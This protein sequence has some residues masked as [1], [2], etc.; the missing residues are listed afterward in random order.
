MLIHLSIKIIASKILAGDARKKKKNMFWGKYPYTSL[1]IFFNELAVAS[2]FGMQ[3]IGMKIL[4]FFFLLTCFWFIIVVF[5][6]S[7]YSNKKEN[8]AQYK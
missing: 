5:K 8:I 6:M 1:D 2:A 3:S 7:T 4:N